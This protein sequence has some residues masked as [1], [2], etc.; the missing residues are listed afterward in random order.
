MD[1]WLYLHRSFCPDCEAAERGTPPWVAC[2][3]MFWC[4]LHVLTCSPAHSPAVNCRP[5]LQLCLSWWLGSQVLLEIPSL[6]MNAAAWF[7]KS[8]C[9]FKVTSQ[10]LSVE[11][12][13]LKDLHTGCQQLWDSWVYCQ[14]CKAQLRSILNSVQ[15]GG[16]KWGTAI[17]LVEVFR[18]NTTSPT[19]KRLL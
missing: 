4:S 2:V 8:S 3:K 11:K 1:G 13:L 7:P 17:F 9:V 18:Q 12:F 16:R 10:W 6:C 14:E 19:A 15:S 5:G